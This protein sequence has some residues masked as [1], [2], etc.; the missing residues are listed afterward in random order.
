MSLLRK[1]TR[2]HASRRA[3]VPSLHKVLEDWMA[4]RSSRDL[5]ELVQAQS[6][7]KVGWWFYGV[8]PAPASGQRE[9]AQ[10]GTGNAA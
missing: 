3:D 8:L 4:S 2:L 7:S 6:V 1:N 9:L 10:V 5:Y